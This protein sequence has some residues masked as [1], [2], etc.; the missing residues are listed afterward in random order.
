MTTSFHYSLP[1]VKVVSLPKPI[2]NLLFGLFRFILMII[3]CLG[4]L[5]TGNIIMTAACLWVA[6]F[7]AKSLSSSAALCS[8]FYKPPVISCICLTSSMI[9]FFSHPLSRFALPICSSFSLWPSGCPFPLSTAK[10]S[11][12]L[13]VW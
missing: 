13:L 3:I 9:I 11:C 1:W 8:G 7:P 6:P 4:F 5:S 2:L 12:P 10:Q